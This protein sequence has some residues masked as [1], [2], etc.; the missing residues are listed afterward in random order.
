MHI[1][2]AL[3]Q[4]TKHLEKPSRALVLPAALYPLLV[5]ALP[6]VTW[7]AIFDLHW[8]WWA[9][10]FALALV[11]ALAAGS[12]S[13]SPKP[14]GSARRLLGWA[15]LWCLEPFIVLTML[16]PIASYVHIWVALVIYGAAAL[17]LGYSLWKHYRG[18]R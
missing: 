6:V 1:P 2:E 3:Y 5:V 15:V 10:G 8:G 7:G 11:W 13:K 16:G 14:F 9:G 4:D 18:K 12:I 17:A